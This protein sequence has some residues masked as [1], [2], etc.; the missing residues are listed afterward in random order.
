M[1]PAL[2][3]LQDVLLERLLDEL[4]AEQC[5]Q[6]CAPRTRVPLL[7]RPIPTTHDDKTESDHA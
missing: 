7:R 1:H 3:N 2:E 4:E 5:R 6:S